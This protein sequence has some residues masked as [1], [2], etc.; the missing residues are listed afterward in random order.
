MLLSQEKL[1]LSQI[2]VVEQLIKDEARLNADDSK[3]DNNDTLEDELN[4]EQTIMREGTGSNHDKQT[5]EDNM[6][7]MELVSLKQTNN[8][9]QVLQHQTSVKL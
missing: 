1:L 7:E 6:Q 2:G 4:A 8:E 5:F 3:T 9:L